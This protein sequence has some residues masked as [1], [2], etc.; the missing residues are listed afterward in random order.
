[1]PDTSPPP[2]ESPSIS[3]QATLR[4][5]ACDLAAQAGAL[6]SE[7][8]RSGVGSVD[9]K[10]SATDMVTAFDRASEALIVGGLRN[11]RP[12]DAIIGE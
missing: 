10:S 7:G 11:V 6:I 2:S 8:R 5:L 9:T 4:Q 3:L 12:D 1:M